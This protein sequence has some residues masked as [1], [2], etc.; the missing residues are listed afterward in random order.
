[1]RLRFRLSVL[2]AVLVAAPLGAQQQRGAVVGRVT[3]KT[4][5]APVPAAEVFIA[6]TTKQ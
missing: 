2:S 3:D 1:M 5:G 4:S 6:G